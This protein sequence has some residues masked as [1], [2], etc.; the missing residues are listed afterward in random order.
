[1]P[2]ALEMVFQS[3]AHSEVAEAIEAA[4]VLVSSLAAKEEGAAI[5]EDSTNR[6]LATAQTMVK[7]AA[8]YTLCPYCGGD[9][10]PKCSNRGWLHRSA[11]SNVPAN[12]RW[13]AYR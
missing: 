6:L 11:Y 3:K 8:P 13:T 1:M 9:R 4:I 5:N 10:C 7:A 12:K 2:V